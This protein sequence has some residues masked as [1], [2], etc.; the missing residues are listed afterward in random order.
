MEILLYILT[1]AFVGLAVGLTGVG[2]GSLMTPLLLLFGYPPHIA[3]GTDLLYASLTKASGVYIHHRQRTINWRVVAILGAGSLPAAGLTILVL[4]Y[5]FTDSQAYSHLLTSSLG[6]MLMLTALV[7]L[8]KKWLVPARSKAGHNQLSFYQRH[9]PLLT[10]LMGIL[11]GTFVT[12]S[13]VG[14]GAIGTAILLVLYPSLMSSRIVGTDLAHAVPLTLVAGLG[15]VFL[16]NVDFHLLFSLLIGSLPAIYVGTRLGSRLPD[17]VMHP[18]LASTL[19][20]LGVK[21]AFF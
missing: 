10:W 9:T 16:G 11:L 6:A 2:G 17:R 3:I 8:A 21:Y 19:L 5:F 7:L 20:A 1:G 4:H 14:A 13:S 12:L 18:V 15:H